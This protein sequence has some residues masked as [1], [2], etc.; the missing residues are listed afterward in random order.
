MIK[1]L[2]IALLFVAAPAAA[3]Q[4]PPQ[5]TLRLSPQQLQVV[6]TALQARPYAE[7]AALL[8]ELDTQIKAAMAPPEKPQ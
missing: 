8:Q 3:Q 4:L 6:V 1:K 2:A 7:V 5:V